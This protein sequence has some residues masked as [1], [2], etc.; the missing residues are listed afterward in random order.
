MATGPPYIIPWA[1]GSYLTSTINYNSVSFVPNNVTTNPALTRAYAILPSSIGAYVKGCISTQNGGPGSIGLG[2]G[3]SSGFPA[4][5][6][7][8]TS[9]S[10]VIY[11]V[12][13][14]T[15]TV[16]LTSTGITNTGGL[17]FVTY[18]GTYMYWYINGLFFQRAQ[19]SSP[20]AAAFIGFVDAINSGT[21]INDI[22][23]DVYWGSGEIP[24][25]GAVGATGVTGPTGWTGRT[26]PTGLTGKTGPTG[27][28]GKTGPTGPAG[29]IYTP[30]YVYSPTGSFPVIQQGQF[31]TVGFNGLTIN[32]P[33]YLSYNY[34]T[35]WFNS[36]ISSSL[37]AYVT[38]SLGYKS[39][40]G[41]VGLAVGAPSTIES[42]SGYYWI[43]INSVTWPTTYPLPSPNTPPF[44]GAFCVTPSS[45]VFISG[46]TPVAGVTG[47]PVS[48]TYDGQSV[49]Y[50]A[51]GALQYSTFASLTSSSLYAAF[52]AGADGNVDAGY[53]TGL[54][55]GSSAGLGPIGATGRTGWTG[56]MGRTGWTG[57]TGA[58]A[59]GPTGP[60]GTGP[61]GAVGATG[62]CYNPFQ[63]LPN[64]SNPTNTTALT[65]PYG[66]QFTVHGQSTYGGIS[67]QIPIL[68]MFINL[69]GRQ[70]FTV[71]DAG[72]AYLDLGLGPLSAVDGTPYTA[73]SAWFRLTSED[74][75]VYVGNTSYATGNQYTAQSIY[76]VVYDGSTITFLIDTAPVYQAS[77]FIG[78]Q[79]GAFAQ[80]SPT[81]LAYATQVATV[82]YGTQGL[83]GLTG[84]RG[85]IGV[86]GWTGPTGAVVATTNTGPTGKTGWTGLTGA[87]GW[88]GPTGVT[89]W[90]GLQ[91]ALG[92]TGVTGPTG[93]VGATG[94][95]GPMGTAT[96][97][98]NTGPTGYTGP[99][100][101]VG[102]TGVEGPQGARGEPGEAGD[103]GP[104]GAQG[105]Q[106]FTGRIG[107]IG[108]RG[109][110][111]TGPTGWTGL[112]G[113]TGMTGWTGLTGMTGPTGPKGDPGDA[114]NTGATGPQGPPGYVGARGPQGFPGPQGVAG[115]A[116]DSANTGATGPRG[117]TGAGYLFLYSYLLS[118]TTPQALPL[119]SS[120]RIV[121]TAFANATLPSGTITG[122]YVHVTQATSNVGVYAVNYITPANNTF[123]PVY[124]N[125]QVMFFWDSTAGG[126]ICAAYPAT[127]NA[128]LA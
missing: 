56:P 68:P 35:T 51:N 98:T 114:T 58:I 72:G 31:P 91:G 124:G 85:V 116:G 40:Y 118:N 115:P 101:R 100:G 127:T 17:L 9:G 49:N 28:T 67:A 126:W 47:I 109:L 20:T 3:D 42:S 82:G 62:Y 4:Y 65:T 123:G 92:A 104:T 36:P 63:L 122:D 73:T 55:W 120:V 7:H 27:L 87:T 103:I 57:P 41:A 25:I 21:T 113:W 18:D 24:A 44:T 34:F 81:S 22:I 50:Y 119:N 128:N 15:G 88:T 117:P 45:V 121:T 32:N 59:T 2:F 48:V 125:A 97:Y 111:V 30:T 23:T 14:A 53:I 108:E 46:V 1:A 70:G 38:G 84:P 77:F 78:N 105:P 19:V 54:M 110:S 93:F 8:V 107:P 69:Y 43:F 96:S 106:G 64:G 16:T 13:M 102:P 71:G 66:V 95:T 10:A 11:T 6:F 80:F 26:G 90:T 5:G 99:T 37:G 33:T 86:T 74:W 29:P 76:S 61:T 94:W 60:I 112:T 83:Q 12:S 79:G 89:G 75:T 39:Q 52:W